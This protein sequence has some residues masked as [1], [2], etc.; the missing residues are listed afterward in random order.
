MVGLNPRAV[1]RCHRA[2]S[3]PTPSPSAFT[4]VVSATR[5]PGASTAATASAARARSGGI[6][7]SFVLMACKITKDVA[8]RRRVERCY[9]KA[10]REDVAQERHARTSPL[11]DHSGPDERQ[12]LA[13]HCAAHREAVVAKAV[14]SDECC[15]ERAGQFD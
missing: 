8:Q 4:C 6:E 13:C 11:R 12:T 5:R 10:S 15:D 7:T 9:T 2:T 3:L 14:G 1:S